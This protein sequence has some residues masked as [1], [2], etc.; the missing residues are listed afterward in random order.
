MSKSN[1]K[2]NPIDYFNHFGDFVSIFSGQK[3][4]KIISS[5][6]IQIKLVDGYDT[7]CTDLLNG[8]VKIHRHQQV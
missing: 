6:K 8:T 4:F 3:D 1:Y 5:T 2:Y 7:F